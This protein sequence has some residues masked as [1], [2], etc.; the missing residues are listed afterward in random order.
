MYNITDELL[1]YPLDN[2]DIKIKNKK[3]F[4]EPFAEFSD[5]FY[6]K[7]GDNG[8]IL[9]THKEIVEYSDSSIE[10]ECSF[11]HV[12]NITPSKILKNDIYS[13]CPKCAVENKKLKISNNQ[14]SSE[15]LLRCKNLYR[16]A[17]FNYHQ[18]NITFNDL[19]LIACV[20][21][22]EFVDIAYAE[23]EN[24][25]VAIENEN[26]D[27]EDLVGDDL[28]IVFNN[29]TDV[30]II[31]KIITRNDIIELMK[32]GRYTSSMAIDDKKVL[33]SLNSSSINVLW[34]R[35]FSKNDNE[36]NEFIRE[37]QE[38]VSSNPK[39]KYSSITEFLNEYAKVINVTF[40]L[41]TDKIPTLAQKLIYFRTITRHKYMNFGNMGV[42]KSL[43]A[44]ALVGNINVNLAL[45][46]LP[47]S[48][49]EQRKKSIREVIPS[50]SVIDD[51][52]ALSKINTTKKT[53]IFLN[54]E[55]FQRSSNCSLNADKLTEL[56]SKFPID[57]LIIDEVHNINKT[58]PEDGTMHRRQQIEHIITALRSNNEN[59]IEHYM[60]GTIAA[61]NVDEAVNTIRLVA[62]EV[63]ILRTNV[64]KSTKCADVAYTHA[65]LTLYGFRYNLP[66]DLYIKVSSREEA[67][68]ISSYPP[69]YNSNKICKKLIVDEKLT[70]TASKDIKNAWEA[71]CSVGDESKQLEVEKILVPARFNYAISKGLVTKG[72]VVF[73][74]YVDLANGTIIPKI[75]QKLDALGLS[76]GLFT[77]GQQCLDR[78]T[79]KN[80]FKKSELDVLLVSS[81]F[82]EG[83]D[84]VQEREGNIALIILSRPWHNADESQLKA[85]LVRKGL[86]AERVDI[87]TV[88]ID[89][90]DI[91]SESYDIRKDKKILHKAQIVEGVEDG[92]SKEVIKNEDIYKNIQQDVYENLG[93]FYNSKIRYGNLTILNNEQCV[94]LP[95]CE[96]ITPCSFTPIAHS[97]HVYEHKWDNS[98]FIHSNLDNIVESIV[99]NPHD[100]G[101][102]HAKRQERIK[103]SWKGN[104]ID[105]VVY[106]IQKYG[107]NLVV[108]DMGCGLAD[109]S[110]KLKDLPNSAYQVYSFDFTNEH[111]PEKERSNIIQCDTT[112][113]KDYIKNKEVDVVVFCL[114]L[115]G[116]QHKVVDY[117]YEAKRIVKD[118]GIIIIVDSIKA[119]RHVEQEET[120]GNKLKDA[121]GLCELRI[122]EEAKILDD[123]LFYVLSK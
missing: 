92:V 83:V 39:A 99:S 114:A 106:T 43:V 82:I 46:I 28:D 109:L 105:H 8:K 57:V 122:V 19:L 110:K 116:A 48:T 56:L 9:T 95:E 89:E 93:E 45:W 79:E 1:D 36:I 23:K 5:K 35:L 72:S 13:C 100:F 103:S 47:N 12:F 7:H 67:D 53:I 18:G 63:P 118:G 59:F 15:D 60:T 123:F 78:D 37:L 68:K 20:S 119:W 113:V 111:V 104:P 34:R 3:V 112:D 75:E 31:K 55:S 21:N 97:P 96:V 11:G 81:A 42:G 29:D 52:Y 80:R 86:V 90:I 2:F 26:L 30:D 76:Y 91:N 32:D 108:A 120:T 44:E 50:I 87:F 94:V 98:V 49:I 71:L 85:R 41:I 107:L 65:L 62:P 64:K 70:F 77:G 102:W 115:W 16:K 88:L 84:G 40:S 101:I 69:I 66:E 4:K 17:V 51:V 10:Y 38:L 73:L 117:L 24:S 33:Q 25:S 74:Q 27:K 6:K 61:N 58:Y 22:I 121:F 54:F 14:Q